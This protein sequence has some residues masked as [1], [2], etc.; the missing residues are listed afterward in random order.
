MMS[1][2]ILSWRFDPDNGILTDTNT[3]SDSEKKGK[4]QEN[5]KFKGEN[6]KKPWKDRWASSKNLECLDHSRTNFSR[7]PLFIWSNLSLQNHLCISFATIL[8]RT[9][10]LFFL[11]VGDSTLMVN[12]LVRW[13]NIQT[14]ARISDLCA[15]ANFG[16][17]FWA[18]KLLHGRAYAKLQ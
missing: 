17:K 8:V 2:D 18:Q 14:S 13:L 1:V 10:R 9:P 11:A 7:W 16:H 4:F 5:G 15:L 6:P 3:L 12:K